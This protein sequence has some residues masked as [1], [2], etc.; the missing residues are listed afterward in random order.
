[1]SA[2]TSAPTTTPPRS[3]WPTRLG[4]LAFV[5]FMAVI[6]IGVVFTHGSSG[7]ETITATVAPNSTTAAKLMQ[8]ILPTVATPT[9]DGVVEIYVTGAVNAPGV[10]RLLA[11]ERVSDAIQAAG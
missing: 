4:F 10:Y 3:K 7:T 8:T 2:P 5:L 6:G 1:M 11:G 9:P